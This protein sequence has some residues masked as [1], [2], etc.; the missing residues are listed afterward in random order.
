[1][2]IDMSPAC[3]AAF[4]AKLF[5]CPMSIAPDI[6]AADN[7][8][9]RSFAATLPFPAAFCSAILFVSACPSLVCTNASPYVVLPLAGPSIEKEFFLLK[10]ICSDAVTLPPNSAREFTAELDPLNFSLSC[11]TLS[12]ALSNAILSATNAP[13]V[14]V[15]PTATAAIGLFIIGRIIASPIRGIITF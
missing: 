14:A 1:M 3:L 2:P 10:S 8:P 13:T 5:A 7:C 6:I 11:K 15:S 9:L 4:I 12:A